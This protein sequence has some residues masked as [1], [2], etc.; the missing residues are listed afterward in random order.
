MAETLT[1]KGRCKANQPLAGVPDFS[2]HMY[3]ANHAPVSWL[4]FEAI[5]GGLRNL[6]ERSWKERFL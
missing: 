4:R 5:P 1:E 3:V 6:A 2:A